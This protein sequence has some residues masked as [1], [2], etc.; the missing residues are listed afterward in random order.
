M[1]RVPGTVKRIQNNAFYEVGNGYA[2][3]RFY[4]VLPGALDEFDISAVTQCNAVLVAPGGL[5]A[6]VLYDNWYYYYVTLEDAKAGTNCQYRREYDAQGLE[7]P[8]AHNGRR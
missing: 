4:L 6:Q 7:I 1:I 3:E 8:H 5:A 2:A